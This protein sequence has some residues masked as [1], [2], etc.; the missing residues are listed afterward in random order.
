M[1]ELLKF[2]IVDVQIIFSCDGATVLMI[3][4]KSIEFPVIDLSQRSFAT[5]VDF[6]TRSVGFITK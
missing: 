3:V 5:K 6:G 4:D 2:L 1:Y